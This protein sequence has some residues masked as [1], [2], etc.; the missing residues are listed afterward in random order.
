MLNSKFVT[1]MDIRAFVNMTSLNVG[2]WEKDWTK[3]QFAVCFYSSICEW[4]VTSF[5]FDCFDTCKML[6]AANNSDSP[7]HHAGQL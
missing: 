5:N 6:K 3:I 4:S 7:L 2:I 1:G